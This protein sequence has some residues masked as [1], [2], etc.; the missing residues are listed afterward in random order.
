MKR[1]ESGDFTTPLLVMCE[2]QGDKRF[3]DR[4][5]GEQI[6]NNASFTVRFA[7][8][9]AGIAGF[10]RVAF[11]TSSTFKSVVKRVLILSDNDD[12]PDKAF[13]DLKASLESVGGFAIPDGER[14]IAVRA[15]SPDICIAMIPF[16][17]SGNLETLCLEAAYSKWDIKGPLDS[18]V[19]ATPAQR[20]GVGK[21]SKMR[22]QA[23]I[24]ATCEAQPDVNLA[25]HL[26][27]GNAVCFSFKHS[28]F[29]E[30]VSFLASFEQ[31][32]T[33]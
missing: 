32:P 5:I 3:L 23:I 17:E 22:M 9:N 26:A 7:G 4:L 27:E 20:W 19:G 18:Y 15:G 24:A 8:G 29:D 30:L 2:G 31:M 21:Q 13:N 28:C 33:P 10:L 6:A 1:Q 12:N 25:N 16:N 11:D 14:V